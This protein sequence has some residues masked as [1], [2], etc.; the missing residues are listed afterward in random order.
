M[1]EGIAVPGGPNSVL[2]CGIFF[3][4]ISNENTGVVMQVQVTGE[5]WD[6][7]APLH[8][9][10]AGANLVIVS[11]GGEDINATLLEEHTVEAS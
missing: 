8:I 5:D 11:E 2:T 9:G 1:H 7:V 6:E 10:T 3:V 4:T